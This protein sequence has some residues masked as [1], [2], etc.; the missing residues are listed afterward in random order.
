MGVL[1]DILQEH[2]VFILYVSPKIETPYS[3][4]MTVLSKMMMVLIHH[5]E[6]LNFCKFKLCTTTDFV[7]STLFVVCMHVW[8][9]SCEVVEGKNVLF[10]YA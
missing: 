2:A 6:N 4:K 9:Y 1:Y 5:H 3:S 8:L 7:P 10:Q